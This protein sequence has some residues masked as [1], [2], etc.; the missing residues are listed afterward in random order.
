VS[1][2]RHTLVQP[3][4]RTEL[5]S[6][7]F[8]TR[9]LRMSVSPHEPASMIPYTLFAPRKKTFFAGLWAKSGQESAV[10]RMRTKP[11]QTGDSPMRDFAIHLSHRPGELGR[12]AN[13]LGKAGINIKSVTA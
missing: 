13:I 12:V 9:L 3:R 1:S 4:A 10:G 2:T 11:F 8:T 6:T 5:S 7:S